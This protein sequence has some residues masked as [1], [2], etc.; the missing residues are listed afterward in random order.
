MT[1]LKTE[2]TKQTFEDRLAKKAPVFTV[3]YE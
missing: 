1:F 2:R 3:E